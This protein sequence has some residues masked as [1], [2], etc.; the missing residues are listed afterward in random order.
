MKTY[1]GVKEYLNA[2]LSGGSRRLLYLQGKGRWYSLDKRL[3]GPQRG[4]D[5]V[6][7]RKTSCPCREYNPK[8]VISYDLVKNT[9]G[10]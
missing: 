7:K 5:A 9:L 10:T 4:L 1:G 8:E 6:E 2:F 3:S